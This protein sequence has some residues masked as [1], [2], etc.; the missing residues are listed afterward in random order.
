MQVAASR[1]SLDPARFDDFARFIRRSGASLL[2]SA[3]DELGAYVT[4]QG[5][6]GV[7]FGVGIFVFCDDES[8]ELPH[9]RT[10]N[11]SGS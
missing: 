11:L 8:D 5:D 6:R 9:K 7:Q 1:L 3:Y 4:D 10:A 2:E